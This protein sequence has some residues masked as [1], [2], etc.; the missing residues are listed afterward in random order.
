MTHTTAAGSVSSVAIVPARGG[1]K[2]IPNKN[3]TLVAGRPLIEWT[4]AAARAARGIDR[5]IVSTD[6]Q[7]IATVARAAGAEVPFLR[8]A[9]LARD[10]SPGTAVI[11]HALNWLAANDGYHPTYAMCLQPTSP[12][13]T[14]EDID[15]A[16]A[17]ALA[18]A[19]DSV[20]S[21]TPAE[22]HP[23]WMKRIDDS[24]RLHPWATGDIAT[25]RQD[26]PPA[27]ALNGAI[28]LALRGVLVER[29]TFYSEATHAYVMPAERS[30]DIDDTW[31]LHL[32]DLILRTRST[33][34][35]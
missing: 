13:R 18:K 29:E 28:Y 1:S 8:P 14:A 31:H 25:R 24:G 23:H 4:I 10:D 35:P 32:A 2:G 9:E 19:C 34:T 11:V 27:Y 15:A 22:H 21:V 5:L 12:L 30:L 3:I 16:I 17:L 20:V 26:L 7:E 6:S 33:S